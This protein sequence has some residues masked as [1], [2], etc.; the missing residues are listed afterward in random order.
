MQFIHEPKHIR[1]ML[2]HVIT[3]DL[4][5]FIISEWIW[6]RAEIV[7]DIGMTRTIRIDADCSRKFVLTTTYVEDLFLR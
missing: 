7:N 3:N 5:K 2:D 4:F 6:K 1:D